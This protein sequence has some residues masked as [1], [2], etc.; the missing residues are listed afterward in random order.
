MSYMTKPMSYVLVIVLG[1]TLKRLGF[2][3][4]ED[5]AVLSRI[6]LNITLPCAFVQAFDG[7]VMQPSMFLIVALG[8]V[9]AGLPLILM[10]LATGGVE[11]RLRVYRMLNI[12]GYNIGCFSVPLLSAFFGSAGVVTA[13][14]FDIG[15]AVI[16]TGGAYAM[17]S[18]L[19]K[20]GGE[21]K[22]SAKDILMKFLRSVPFD[23]YMLLLLLSALGVTLPEAVF[24]LTQP[25]GQ[26]NAFIA[27]LIIGL[28]FEPAGD[29]ALL[30]ETARELFWR[31]AFAALSA[32]AIYFL[33]PFDLL[34]RQVL[35]VACFA[36]LSSLAPI[37]T[38]RC[39]GD[40]ALASFTNSASIAISLVCMLGL[41]MMF[42]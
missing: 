12:G 33:T 37:Y 5:R 20:T 30:S 25:M 21:E 28:A 7:L 9:C 40:A 11:K 31:Y 22:E 1:Y 36:P 24:T 6:M 27:M 23:T 17:T 32:A 16:M 18:T 3:K 13:C 42:M 41:S 26:A 10:Y 8:L 2:F 38:E 4:P 19:L 29:K 35:A 14:L 39:K 34:T 15:N